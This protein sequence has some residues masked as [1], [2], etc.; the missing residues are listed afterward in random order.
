MN[1]SE[2]TTALEYF[3]LAQE[4]GDGSQRL[5]EATEATLAKLNEIHRILDGDPEQPA[6]RWGCE[7]IE[8]VGAALE[9]FG[10]VIRSPDDE[11]D[12]DNDDA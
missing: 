2:V 6:G 12:E 8:Y 7:E 3:K 5:V 9:D 4:P 11:E 10:Y 1:I